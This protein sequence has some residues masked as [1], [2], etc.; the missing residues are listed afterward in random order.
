MDFL[1]PQ[2]KLM[3]HRGGLDVKPS[4]SDVIG[5]SYLKFS[6]GADGDVTLQNPRLEF[7]WSIWDF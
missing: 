4:R 5:W 3:P 2:N 7:F 1:P 6:L